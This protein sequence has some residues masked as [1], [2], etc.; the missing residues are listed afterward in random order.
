[1]DKIENAYAEILEKEMDYMKSI[2]NYLKYRVKM[3]VCAVILSILAIAVAGYI[4]L[5]DITDYISGQ[6]PGIM[7]SNSLPKWNTTEVST[8]WVTPDKGYTKCKVLRVTDGD[9]FVVRY[10]GEDNYVRMIGID[11]PESVHSDKN[12]NTR[13]GKKASSYTKKRLSGKTVYLEFDV[14]KY[15]R[16]GRLL[17]YVYTKNDGKYI[18]YNKTL[19]KSGYA[20]AVC[21]EPNHKYKDVFERLQ[22]KAK[23]QKK[24]FWKAGYK[25]AF[26]E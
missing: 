2:W 13:W 6:Q 24:G 14:S 25:K 15:D 8:D 19:V 18:M 12:R 16:Y 3:K 7:L 11:T 4:K 20:R 23:K 5:P 21:Y 1:M 17:A 26:P 10:K 9:T 22:K